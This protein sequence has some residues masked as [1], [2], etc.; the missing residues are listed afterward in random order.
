MKTS[1]IRL[2]TSEKIGLIHNLA[3]MISAGISIL[4][5]IDSLLE[6]AKGNQKKILDTLLDD[7]RQGQPIHKSFQKFPKTFS[8]V[9]TNLIKASEE[10]GTLD[11]T[12]KDLTENTR[13]EA[14]FADKVRSTM[15]Y[16]AFIMVVFLGVL[17]L[18]LTFVIPKISTVF[19]RMKVDLPLP[20]RIMMGASDI[21]MNN[22]IPLIIG[23]VIFI[24]GF[25]FLYR[26]KKEVF[27]S[28]FFSLPVVTRL[29]REIDLTRFAR[30]FYLLLSA[31]VPITSALELCQNVVMKKDV[32]KAII[33][34]TNHV[35]SGHPLSEAMKAKKNIFP[36][37]MIKM[38]EAGEKTGSL[39]DSMQ[40]ASE[41]MD[42]EVSKTLKTVTAMMEPM[43]LVGVG[44]MIGGMMV[45]I[46][47]PMYNI[48][49]QV[50]AR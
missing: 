1:N 26:W 7:L 35:S 8:P 6:D 21:I 27:M 17:I 45:A 30:S 33:Y 32:S 38:V 20:T 11:T 4:E 29:V 16:P 15:M 14:E 41:F 37:M 3:T 50:G 49:G 44:V 5:A 24:V 31:G 22:T 13:K 18:M 47:A 48:I 46:I 40:D 19:A 39:D 28:V 9:M 25:F 2:S 12:L 10:A 36:P 42:Y 23:I 43:M 34:M